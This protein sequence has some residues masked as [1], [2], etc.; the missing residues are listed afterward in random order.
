[1]E[2]YI[3]N[4]LI[5]DDTIENL[6]VLAGML[7]TEGYVVRPVPSGKLALLAAKLTKPDII[8]LD[9]N[10]PIMDGYEVCTELKADP[11][12]MDVPV[13]FISA[14]SDL[15]DKSRAFAVGGVDY[16][17]KP[18]KLEEVHMRVKTHLKLYM[19][20]S[21]LQ[22]LVDE[23]VDELTKSHFSIIVA[24]AK[25]AQ[26]RDDSTGTHLDRIRL[27]C[28][29]LAH[30]MGKRPEYAESMTAEMVEV[31]AEASALHDIGKVGIPDSILLKP[32]KLT[33]EEFEVIK[34]H[35]LIGASTL[36]EVAIH[37]RN[38]AFIDIG[39]QIAR[40]HHEHWDG[41][42]YPDGLKGEEIPFAARI[43]AI[44]DVYDALISERYY[45]KAFPHEQC[46]QIINDGKGSHFDPAV[47]DVFNTV[48]QDLLK[49]SE[50][51]R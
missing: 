8:L 7:K 45:K 10:M 39:I 17:T 24:L 44:V 13:I 48:H 33:T 6:N 16:I 47:I 34:S 40:S 32:G 9:I 43:M 1:M 38:N 14:L 11:R 30:E 19:L 49:A 29:I 27:Y 28:R 2:K 21:R 5:V 31:I 12:L 41:T 22:S 46:V 23:Q 36:K 3:P 18:F 20:S 25:L 35:T 51:M 50:S 15:Q 42:G 4:I 26:S 37:D